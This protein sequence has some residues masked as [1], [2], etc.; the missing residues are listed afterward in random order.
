MNTTPAQFTD[1]RHRTW[2]IVLNYSLAKRL[3]DVTALDFVNYQDGKALLAIHDSDEK[4]VQ[5]LWLLC[6]PQA[7]AAGV[8]EE[9]F[10]AGLGG[11]AL[12]QGIEALEQALLNFSRPAKRQ[13]IAAIRDKAHELV[14]AQ[15]NLTE[16]KLRSPKV[17]E[18]L[19]AKL[20][21]ASAEIDRR[22]DEQL[23]ASPTSG[24]SGSNGPASSASIRAP[25]RSAS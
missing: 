18:F 17:T 12:E 25:T 6:E 2:R 21:E 10:G 24:S 1:D 8:S 7:Q 22:I 4:L 3:R 16:T 20:A 23:T 13:A 9:E 11:D 14:A 19:A 5:V 15:T